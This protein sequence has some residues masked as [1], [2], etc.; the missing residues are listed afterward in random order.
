MT[1]GG[2]G[3]TGD[4]YHIVNFAEDSGEAVSVDE[5]TSLAI[6]VAPVPCQILDISLAVTTAVGTNST[7]TWSIQI[8]NQTGDV[9]LLSD[10]FDTD[11]DTPVSTTVNGGRILPADALTSLNYNGAETT[12][13]D[14]GNF[15]QNPTLA[16]GDILILTATKANAP[17]A[18]ANPVVV[19]TYRV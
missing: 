10:A 14:G 7:N 6:F 16:K 17:T 2:L 11:S 8:Q 1:R 18:L 15:L 12:V 4:Q 9:D 5:T 13:T 3:D 19:V